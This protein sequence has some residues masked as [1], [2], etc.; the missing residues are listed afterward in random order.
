MFFRQ[1]YPCGLRAWI[2]FLLTVTP[3]REQLPH[4]EEA[5][6]LR[7]SHQ[8]LSRVAQLIWNALAPFTAFI[9]PLPYLSFLISFLS[10]SFFLQVTLPFLETIK[11][12]NKLCIRLRSCWEKNKRE[13]AYG[14]PE[15]RGGSTIDLNKLDRKAT[16][17][18][19]KKRLEGS[20]KS[21][22]FI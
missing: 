1:M 13:D 8:E 4:V 2:L 9:P 17:V 7:G 10:I 16:Q 18:T 21:H 11:N 14:V 22:A 12:T 3:F 15:W 6:A 19:F 20:E 5:G